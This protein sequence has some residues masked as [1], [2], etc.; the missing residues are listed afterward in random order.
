MCALELNFNRDDHHFVFNLKKDPDIFK[1]EKLMRFS[2]WRIKS[3]DLLSGFDSYEQSFNHQKYSLAPKIQKVKHN[4]DML[5]QEA[6]M[7]RL[8]KM[9]EL[10]HMMS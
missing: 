6:Q 3:S 9:T 10:K 8:H 7:H 2:T 5:E 1:G 4:A